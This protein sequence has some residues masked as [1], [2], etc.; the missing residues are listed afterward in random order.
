MRPTL[1]LYSDKSTIGLEIVNWSCHN[2]CCSWSELPP[3][4]SARA[5]V[6]V[7]W[8]SGGHVVAVGGLDNSRQ[9][10]ATV[11]MLECSWDT[12]ESA[13][14]GWRYVAPMN[15][16]RCVHAVAF[17]HDKIVAAGGNERKSIECFTLPNVDFPQGQWVLIRPMIPPT[18][19]AGL[20]PF[21]DHLLSVGKC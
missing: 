7:E 19:L 17:I 4:Q 10:M 13:N 5:G 12:E 6:A 8:L 1:T 3:L 2:I 9:P 16:T 21:G 15:H 11:E 20:H 18:C 14:G